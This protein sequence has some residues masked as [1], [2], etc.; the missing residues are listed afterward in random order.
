MMEVSTRRALSS[1]WHG[2]SDCSAAALPAH[3]GS[4]SGK[5]PRCLSLNMG[6]GDSSGRNVCVFVKDCFLYAHMCRIRT[7]KSAL[8]S[9]EFAVD[10]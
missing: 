5:R 1:L 2:G 6:T 8:N 7:E 9:A 3:E 4:D 10:L